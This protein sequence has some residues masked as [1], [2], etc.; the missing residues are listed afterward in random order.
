MIAEEKKRSMMS[1]QQSFIELIDLPD[2][3]LLK[4]FNEL[5]NVDVLYS[6][7]GVNTRFDKIL[8]DLKFTN[9]LTLLECG[10]DD[11]IYS[12]PDPILA[13]FCSQIIPQIFNK[14]KWLDI[15]ST[16]MERVLLAA[17][18][19]NLNGLGLYNLTEETIIRIFSG[20]KLN[21]RIDTMNR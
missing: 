18:Y 8:N 7:M 11:S 16:S 4:I 6:L 9:S 12:L 10:L 2:E 21:L 19:S 14:I 20:K 3:I 15:E 13:R 1:K 5:N 17:N